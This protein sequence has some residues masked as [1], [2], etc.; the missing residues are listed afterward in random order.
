MKSLIAR[1]IL[2]IAGAVEAVRKALRRARHRNRDVMY[3]G[4]IGG[5]KTDALLT[6]ALQ[7]IDDPDYKG[8]IIQSGQSGVYRDRLQN[9]GGVFDDASRRWVF[10]SGATLQLVDITSHPRPDA[11]V[12]PGPV[13]C[14][15]LATPFTLKDREFLKHWVGGWRS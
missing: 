8:M 2:K 4:S 10:P 11:Y 12:S 1:T 6:L 9:A 7:S 5:G 15:E 14:E 3:G 13:W